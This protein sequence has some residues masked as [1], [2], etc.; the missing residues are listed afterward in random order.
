ML[1]VRKRNE[2]LASIARKAGHAFVLFSAFVSVARADNEAAYLNALFDPGM[3]GFS[4]SKA[5]DPIMAGAEWKVSDAGTDGH[6][7]IYTSRAQVLPNL[8]SPQHSLI[9]NFR[10]VG[11]NPRGI[12]YVSAVAP[13]T[14]FYASLSVSGS[15]EYVAFLHP[16]IG[17]VD[18]ILINPTNCVAL[19]HALGAKSNDEMVSKA[20]QCQNALD[21]MLPTQPMAESATASQDNP[22]LQEARGWLDQLSQ[23]IYRTPFARKD[24][25]PWML[26]ESFGYNFANWARLCSTV[27][28]FAALA[29]VSPGLTAVSAPQPPPPL[30]E[31]V[32]AKE[33]AANETPKETPAAAAPETKA[34]PSDEK[35]KDEKEEGDE[36]SSDEDSSEGT[37]A[38]KVKAKEK[39]APA[40]APVKKPRAGKKRPK[41]N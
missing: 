14:K 10:D 25:A 22:M 21:Q 33:K 15:I 3:G 26:G 24:G 31:R 8:V 34:K 36:A 37:E 20:T 5:G 16:K 6:Q 13:G 2:N 30:T 28:S 41:V 27:P 9:I 18:V 29:G 12:G 11:R 7:V 35:A 1:K 19:R 38:A 17:K 4:F 23:T 32:P 40:K 39:A